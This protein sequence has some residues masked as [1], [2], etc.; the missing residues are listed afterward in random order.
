MK[1]PT[2][3][4]FAEAESMAERFGYLTRPAGEIPGI[5]KITAETGL[6]YSQ[7]WDHLT[8]QQIVRVH[9]GLDLKPVALAAMADPE[10]DGLPSAAMLAFQRAIAGCRTEGNSWGMIMQRFGVSEG[11]VRKAFKVATGTKSEGLRNGKG[12]RWLL[13]EPALYLGDREATGIALPAPLPRSE[14]RA[15]A[16]RLDALES[17]PENRKGLVALAKDL[18]VP[19]KGNNEELA[20]AIRRA[21]LGTP[22]SDAEVA[23]AEPVKA[24]NA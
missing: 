6:N 10:K 2:T 12:G 4:V 23:S 7:A 20:E 8:R 24:L 18:G 14:V 1:N 11:I 21:I 16:R 9:T 15:Y 3:A 13:D 22:A 5:G 17:L 19:V